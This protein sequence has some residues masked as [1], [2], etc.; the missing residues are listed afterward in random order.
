LPT[1]NISAA[2]VDTLPD[3][4]RCVIGSS[5]I[6]NFSKLF[7]D[8]LNVFLNSRLATNS[9]AHMGSPYYNCIFHKHTVI[10]YQVSTSRGLQSVNAHD[11][12]CVEWG[13]KLY[14]LT[15]SLSD[16]VLHSKSLGQFFP[17]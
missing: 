4:I 6:P 3:S 13:V 10:Y 7:Q 12:Y 11:L 17:F 9:K 8:Y 5:E 2:V 14:S 15:H 1:A 16:H